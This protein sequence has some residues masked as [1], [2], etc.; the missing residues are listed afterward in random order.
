MFWHFQAKKTYDA[1]SGE[2]EIAD[3]ALKKAK[4]N[5]NSYATKEW[6]RVR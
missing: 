3:C 1:K 2:A 4:T 5:E 6:D